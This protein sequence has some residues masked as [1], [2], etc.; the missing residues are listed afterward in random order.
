MTTYGVYFIYTNNTSVEYNTINNAGGGGSA[1]AFTFYG[2]LFS[3]VTGS[4]A[5]N[6][7]AFT[8][9]T[10]EHQEVNGIY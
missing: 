4:V 6:N 7:N 3:T 5:C 9:N 10:L 2:V 1:H 8:L